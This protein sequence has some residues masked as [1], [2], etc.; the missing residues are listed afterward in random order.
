[1]ICVSWA[2]PSSKVQK[3]YLARIRCVLDER[4]RGERERETIIDDDSRHRFISCYVAKSIWIVVI[5]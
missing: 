4:K 2:S 1:M 3:D 5:S